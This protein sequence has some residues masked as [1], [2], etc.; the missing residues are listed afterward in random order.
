[1]LLL[2]LVVCPKWAL[3]FF[4][5]ITI[6][7]RYGYQVF[8]WYL[9]TARVLAQGGA[10]LVVLSIMVCVSSGYGDYRNVLSPSKARCASKARLW[11]GVWQ[12]ELE[13]RLRLRKVRADC[14][15]RLQNQKEREVSYRR[16]NRHQARTRGSWW[17]NQ[18]LFYRDFYLLR[19]RELEIL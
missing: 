18:L 13:M 19:I 12:V 10:I 1:M 5:S 14:S 15:W 2:L 4:Y 7:A 9:T 8:A 16:N 3:M 17:F 6:G 11:K